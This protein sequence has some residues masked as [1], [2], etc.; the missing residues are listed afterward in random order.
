[1]S[2]PVTTQ[3]RTS[4][5]SK[6]SEQ[7][8][9]VGYAPQPGGYST[10]PGGYG[11]Q[12]EAQGF[13]QWMT[14][15]T[16]S[17]CPPGLE[18]LTTIDQLLVK[19]QVEIVEALTSFECANKYIMINSV[20]QQVYFAGEESDLCMRQCC[21][22][23][24]GFVIHITDNMGQE[25][26]RITREFKC[27]AGCCWC[28]NTKHCAFEVTVEA[29]V[30][31]VVGKVKQTCSF[32]RPLFDITTPDDDV[33]FRI[34]G[35]I[36]ICDGPCCLQDQ[37]FEVLDHSETNSIGTISKQYAGF[38]NE[39]FTNADNFGVTFPLDLDVKMKA[40]IIGA[41]FLIDFM[42]FERKN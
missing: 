36:C 8:P 9:P 21:G 17:N 12:P 18:Y 25:V 1:M 24:R 20:G 30:G 4:D 31:Q 32:I 42:F 28:A 38:V 39:M 35:P 27:C 14:R 19:Q 10:Q 26:M 29:P 11:P 40:T 41:L 23:A 22:P 16:V 37:K 34:K 6:G 3:P 13:Q 2:T 15:P 7:P 33:V 5:L